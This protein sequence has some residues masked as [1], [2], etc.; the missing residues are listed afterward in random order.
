MVFVSMTSHDLLSRTALYQISDPS[1]T[2]QSDDVELLSLHDMADDSRPLSRR[3]DSGANRT[4]PPPIS[5]SIPRSIRHNG[6]TQGTAAENHPFPFVDVGGESTPPPRSS[7][8]PDNLEFNVSTTCDDPSSDE[9]E[10]SSPATLADLYRRDRL[11]PPYDSSAEDDD[12]YNFES[13]MRRAGRTGASSSHRRSR[14]KVKPSRIEVV[15]PSTDA[16][17]A[18]DILAP[19]AKFFIERERSVVSIKF[20]PPV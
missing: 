8:H 7:D 2:R 1:A 19:H 18:K 11:P 15:W 13:V 12:D 10:P 5:N 3:Q 20:D 6:N 16:A 9:E 14:R 4:V 17:K